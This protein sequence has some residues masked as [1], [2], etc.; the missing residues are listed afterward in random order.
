MQAVHLF[1]KFF[2][3]GSI[4]ADRQGKKC[5]NSLDRVHENRDTFSDIET[6]EFRFVI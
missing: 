2:R 5:E 3:C 6:Q 1:S 4:K